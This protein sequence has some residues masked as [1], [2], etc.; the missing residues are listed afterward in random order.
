MQRGNAE[1]ERR[2]LFANWVETY[3][4]LMKRTCFLYL[5][6]MALAEDAVQDAFLKA[7]QKMDRFEGRHPGSAKAWLM[8]I[9]INVCRDYQRSAWWRHVDRRKAVDELPLAEEKAS[10][11]DRLLLLTILGLP[12]RY[13]QVILLY[14]YHDMTQQEVAEVLH[15]SLTTVHRRLKKAQALLKGQ[16][17]EEEGVKWQPIG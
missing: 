16:L 6:D 2:V 14:Y 4:D 15:V 1:A 7:W 3:G 10:P 13:K 11:E 17:T 12:H 9:A 5:S 8:R